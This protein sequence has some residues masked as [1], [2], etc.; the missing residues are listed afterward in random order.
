MLE[1]LYVIIILIINCKRFLY[2]YIVSF[3]YF[4]FHEDL[5]VVKYPLAPLKA[6][7]YPPLSTFTTMKLQN[8]ITSRK[9][10]DNLIYKKMLPI[11]N[12]IRHKITKYGI[13][14]KYRV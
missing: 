10:K 4:S 12:T 3:Y 5:Y 9:I 8:L 13:I 7:E 11:L 1:W 14:T 6:A 2:L